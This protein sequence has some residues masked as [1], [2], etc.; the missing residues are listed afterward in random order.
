MLKTEKHLRLSELNKNQKWLIFFA[1][2]LVLSISTLLCFSL[3]NHLISEK[4][5]LATS[6][7]N[8]MARQLDR[9]L[10]EN[11]FATYAL[12]ALIKNGHGNIA[13]FEGLAKE[14]IAYQPDISSLQLAPNGIIKHIVPLSGNEKALGHNLLADEQRN[15][16]ARLALQTK[17]LTLAGPFELLQGGEAVIGRLPVF[18]DDEAK[19]FWGFTTAL[20]KMKDF[21]NA[22]QIE[23][24]SQQGFSYELWRTHPNSGKKHVIAKSQTALNGEPIISFLDVA[25]GRWNLSVTPMGGWVNPNRVALEALSTLVLSMITCWLIFL[26]F[27]G[28]QALE[29]SETRYQKLYT[30]SPVMLHSIDRNNKILSTSKFWLNTLGYSSEEVIGRETIEFMT[31]SSRKYVT[32]SV[33]PELYKNGYC[34][35]LPLQ[36]VTKSGRLIDVLLS[37]TAERNYKNEITEMLVV[38]QDVTERK[39]I[40]RMKS[41]FVSTVSHEL[42]TPLTSISGALGLI[43]G[44]ALGKMPDQAKQMLE[45]AHKNSLRLTLLINDLLDMEKLVAGK[46]HFD[47]QQ[48]S[49]TPI[50][51]SAMESVRAY[52]DLYQVHIKLISSP[53]DTQILVDNMRLQQVL[54]NFLSNAAKFSPTGGQIE[55]AI[56]QS[57]DRVR[58]EVTDHGSGIP[59]EFRSRIFQKFS[60]AD[61]SD[62]RQKGGT[63]LGLAISK[64]I[65]ERM[66]GTIGFESTEGQG[67]RFYFELPVHNPG[68]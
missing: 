12:A 56:R 31:E 67:T 21:L 59:A 63:G 6:T 3:E 1:G 26:Y 16:E 23:K 11:L 62:T 37:A 29:S 39:E 46:M 30:A 34:N 57:N 13:G 55:I 15:I 42:R 44:G 51:E 49:L 32:D 47:I 28:S 14:F 38:M 50:V 19:S 7:S 43:N 40:D 24:L 5:E 22:V 36:L 20:I 17:T 27:D 10:N 65:I 45:I 9:H 60:Q 48:Q 53:G 33:L 35:N 54:S 2:F 8:Q 66:D 25:N 68:K 58:V 52:A 41:E 18:L 64:E 4:R 61:S